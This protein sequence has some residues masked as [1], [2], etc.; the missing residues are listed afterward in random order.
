[1]LNRLFS[2]IINEVRSGNEKTH[3]LLR[4]KEG[5]LTVE[6]NV[7]LQIV[8][9]ISKS[10]MPWKKKEI[11]LEAKNLEDCWNQHYYLSK[12]IKLPS[13]PEI[14]SEV[15]VHL[16]R[17]TDQVRLEIS[18]I[19]TSLNNNFEARVVAKTKPCV[20][21]GKAFEE[22]YQL[23]SYDPDHDNT[24]VQRGMKDFEEE[25]LESG[26]IYSQYRDFYFLTDASS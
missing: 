2:A 14:G 3:S 25:L 23:H 13:I 10:Q 4:L 5:G 12:V 26:W 15:R 19:V 17:Y 21:P 6:L 11:I 8:E 24:G 16:T 22:D 9:K 18:D 20:Y 7:H 1:M